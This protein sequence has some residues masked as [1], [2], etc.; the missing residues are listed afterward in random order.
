MTFE[1]S[2]KSATAPAEAKEPQVAE[3]SIVQTPVKYSPVEEAKEAEEYPMLAVEELLTLLVVVELSKP[4]VEEGLA[5]Q[6]VAAEPLMLMVEE[7]LL[8]P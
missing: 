4:Q 1:K 2:K 7:A 6:L 5:M 8:M 3:H